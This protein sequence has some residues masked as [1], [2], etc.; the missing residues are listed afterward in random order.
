MMQDQNQEFCPGQLLEEL[1]HRVLPHDLDPGE[2]TQVFKQV[3]KVCW[4]QRQFKEK[5][6]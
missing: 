1:A 2:D 3:D 6:C 4:D 5:L